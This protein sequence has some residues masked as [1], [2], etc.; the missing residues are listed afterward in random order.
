VICRYH[1]VCWIHSFKSI[2]RVV[3]Q[4]HFVEQFLVLSLLVCF[5]MRL[6]THTDFHSC[7][8]CLYSQYQCMTFAYSPH[9]CKHLLFYFFICFLVVA[10]LTGIRWNLSI[11]LIC[12]SFMVKK[13]WNFFK[14]LLVIKISS[15]YCLF[16]S[17]AHL[18]I[19]LFVHLVFNC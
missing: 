12:N 5:L 13:C 17:F 8:T 2:S 1:S 18:L 14:Y 19:G 9:P 11:I 4:D 10:I 3:E 7:F 16:N 15:G 6:H